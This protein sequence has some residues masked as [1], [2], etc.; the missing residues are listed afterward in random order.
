MKD[1][2]YEALRDLRASGKS[3]HEIAKSVESS[4]GFSVVFENGVIQDVVPRDTITHIAHNPGEIRKHGEH[5][6]LVDRTS[7]GSH[8]TRVNPDGN[9][10]DQDIN[11]SNRHTPGTKVGGYTCGAD[12]LP[13]RGYN[14]SY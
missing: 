12:G 8:Q 1:F 14:D 9:V 5:I 13:I 4:G 2:Q 6:D 7:F 11:F 3:D 10:S